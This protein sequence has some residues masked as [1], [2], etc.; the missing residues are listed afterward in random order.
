MDIRHKT[1]TILNHRSKLK[2]RWSHLQYRGQYIRFFE[3][4][5]K[6][7]CPEKRKKDD[8]LTYVLL[9]N[10][11]RDSARGA[12]QSARPPEEGV[13]TIDRTPGKVSWVT[14]SADSCLTRED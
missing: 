8:S 12:F 13:V 4:V 3:F 6:M 11:F 1:E 7:S 5:K 14:D 2:T 10:K 9:G